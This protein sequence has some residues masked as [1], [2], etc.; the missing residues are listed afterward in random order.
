VSRLLDDL[1]PGKV[2]RLMA[3]DV[4]AWHGASGGG[5]HPD[6]RVWAALPAPW[7]ALAR[8]ARCTRAMVEAACRNH[9]VDPAGWT[10]PR[11]PKL[12]VP[13]RPTPELVHG[14]AIGSPGLATLL[15]EA[16]WFTGKMAAP[17]AIPV[18]VDRD[19]HGAALRADE[20]DSG[21]APRRRTDS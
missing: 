7:D 12:P 14:V 3:A 9:G 6:T 21:K 19:E 20:D 18:V 8:K 1:C 15:R 11:P 17:V 5:L 2:L 10:G 4:A 13:F 16:G